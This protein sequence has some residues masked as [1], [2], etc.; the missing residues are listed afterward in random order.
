MRQPI[1]KSSSVPAYQNL[2]K[3][4]GFCGFTVKSL[5]WRGQRDLGLRSRPSIT[6]REGRVS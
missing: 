6:V 3:V 2:R 4:D 5:A 1:N